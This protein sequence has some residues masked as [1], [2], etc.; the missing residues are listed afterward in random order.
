MTLFLSFSISRRASFAAVVVLPA[1]CRPARNMTTGG[2]ARRLS[3]TDSL[4]SNDTS[5]LWMILI[6]AWP[7]V[8]LLPTSSP[9]ARS[10]ILSMNDLTT[11]SATS[12][13]SN[14]RRT[15]RNVSLMLDSLSR[16]FPV[17]LRAAC[18]RRSERLSNMSCRCPRAARRQQF[19]VICSSMFRGYGK[20]RSDRNN[21]AARKHA[22]ILVRR[23]G[24]DLGQDA[25]LLTRL[26]AGKPDLGF[27]IQQCQVAAQG[28]R[29]VMAGRFCKL[30]KFV[31]ERYFNDQ[32]PEV[33][34]G[35]Q[36]RP[37]CAVALGVATD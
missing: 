12:A 4:P 19:I 36:Y 16:P 35:I 14:A 29:A 3:G 17:R 22:D 30:G 5:S 11:G 6:S 23:R 13:S 34:A 2:C 20:C 37:Q 1:P 21:G 8:R 26:H 7:G 27:V 24:C 28:T 18:E 31:R 9:I 10:L 15:W 33:I 25:L 32:G